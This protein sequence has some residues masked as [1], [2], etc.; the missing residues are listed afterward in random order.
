MKFQNGMN[1]PVMMDNA[2]ERQ[3]LTWLSNHDNQQMML[4]DV[5]NLISQGLVTAYELL[6]NISLTS[7]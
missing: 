6:F 2:K 3:P 4:R 7:K 5:Q 1:L